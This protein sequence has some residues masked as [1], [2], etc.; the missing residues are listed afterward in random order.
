MN[1]N[2]S[3]I[4]ALVCTGNLPQYVCAEARNAHNSYILVDPAKTTEDDVVDYEKRLMEQ[5][6]S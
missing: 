4:A 6:G 3:A 2:G 1:E 5:P